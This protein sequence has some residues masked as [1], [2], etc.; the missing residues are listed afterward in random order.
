MEEKK[1]FKGII[2]KIS[3]KITPTGKDMYFFN[4]GDMSFSGF[5]KSIANEGELIEFEYKDAIVGDKVYHNVTYINNVKKVQT[6]GEI[7]GES[8]KKKRMA[9]MMMVAKDI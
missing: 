2:E 5:G 1:L 6:P 4:I 7:I 8:A 9:E 3:Y